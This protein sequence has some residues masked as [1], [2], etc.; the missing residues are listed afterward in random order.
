VNDTAT[1]YGWVSILLHWITALLILYLLYLGSTIGSLEGDERM[2]AVK[3]HTSVAVAS[4]VLLLGRVLW[5]FVCG[6]PGPTDEQRGW[7][8]TLGKYTHY[9]MLG[10]LVVMLVT[11]PLM[12]FSYGSDIEVFDWFVV[13]TP[14]EASFGLAGV[15]HRLHATAALILFLGILLHIGGVYKHTAFN[16]DGTLA[17]IIIPG[18]E[19]A[20]TATRAVPDHNE[21]DL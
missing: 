13:P 19:S 6:H 21:G 14:L 12:Q 9:T 8:F 10:A 4:Y 1:G 17:K 20:R 18:R 5:R 15:L 11:G 2:L 7:A 16:Q 3:R